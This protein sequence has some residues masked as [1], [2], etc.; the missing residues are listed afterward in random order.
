MGA[1]QWFKDLG[2]DLFTDNLQADFQ[3]VLENPGHF[4]KNEVLRRAANIGIYG[5]QAEMY[6]NSCGK[7]H[8]NK[9]G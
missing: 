2:E 6:A 3:E 1:L 8:S 4:T 5:K 9:G 7:G